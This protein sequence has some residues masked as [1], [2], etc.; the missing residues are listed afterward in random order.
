[1]ILDM[2]FAEIFGILVS[3][4]FIEMFAGISE[5]LRTGKDE[6]EI[7][8]IDDT[9][10]RGHLFGIDFCGYY[11]AHEEH[12]ALAVVYDVVNLFGLELILYRNHDGTIG[13]NGQ[14]GYCPLAAISSANSYLVAL[15]HTAVLEQD[16][17]LFYLSGYIMILQCCSFVIGKSIQMPIVDDALLNIRVETWY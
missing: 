16:V 11:I 14:E 10:E 7:G 5:F 6:R 9:F 17:E 12:L 8:K 2:F 4:D 1:M 3:E 13:N 15:Y